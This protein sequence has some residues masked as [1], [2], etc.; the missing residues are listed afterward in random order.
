MC[1]VHHS[2]KNASARSTRG[3]VIFSVCLFTGGGC[4]PVIG[5]RSLPCLWSLVLSGGGGAYPV[6]GPRSFLGPRSRYPLPS[7]LHSQEQHRGNPPPF[8]QPWLG[9]GYP[10]PPPPRALHAMDRYSVGGMRLAFS[11]W[12]IQGILSRLKCGNPDQLYTLWV[13]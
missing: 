1:N 13:S 10:P 5:P 2:V 6:S 7:L 11:C 4:T 3:K 8:P 12:K 9:Q